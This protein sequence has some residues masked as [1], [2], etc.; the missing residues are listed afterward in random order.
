[1]SMYYQQTIKDNL[2]EYNLL[3]GTEECNENLNCT[4]NC[5]TDIFRTNKTRSYTCR[6]ITHMY[7][8][9]FMNRYASEIYHIFSD[10]LPTLTNGDLILSLGCGSC[11]ETIGIERYCRDK[12]IGKIEY[13][14][15]DSN[16]IWKDSS[17][18]CCLRT[19]NINSNVVYK[20][21]ANLS[22]V[23]SRV[24]VFLL[25]YCLSDIKNHDDLEKFLCN[26]FLSYINLLPNDSY[27]VIND[28]NHSK[29]WEDI[30]DAWTKT[31][32]SSQYKINNYFFDPSPKNCNPRGNR[33][34]DN[35]LVFDNSNLNSEINNYFQ[36]NLPCCESGI[37]IIHKL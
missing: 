30:F 33:M 32:N 37:T 3:K 28:Q 20:N 10:V 36:Q 31:L 17:N 21:N 4:T 26:D 12:N 35:R 15:I 29:E 6:T 22:I 25:N 13:L 19:Q 18:Y 2:R 16:L 8:L 1:M 11:M 5:I 34:K 27:I 9:R 24:K 7:V 14:G 23:L